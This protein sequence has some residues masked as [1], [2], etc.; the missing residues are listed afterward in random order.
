M[1]GQIESSQS[2][3]EPACKWNGGVVDVDVEIASDDKFMRCCY[4]DR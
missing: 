2:G 1:L 3:K 4:S